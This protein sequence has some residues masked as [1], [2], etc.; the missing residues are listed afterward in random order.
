MGK[1]KLKLFV[2]NVLIY[3]LGGIMSKVVHLVMVPILTYL[4]PTTAFFGLSDNA[5][6]LLSFGIYLSIMGMFDA[7]YRLFFEKQD[8]MYKREVCSTTVF[9]T[10][11]TSVL[12]SILLILLK[13]VISPIVFEKPEYSYLIYVISLTTF[14]SATNGIISA[15]T[16]MQN[17]RH[18]FLITNTIGPII[19][20]AISVP[21]ILKGFYVIAMP[22]AALI[23]GLIIEISFLI[24]NHKWFSPKLFRKDLLKPL[25]SIAIPL[26]PNFLVYWVFNSC[27]KLMITKIL[28]LEQNGIYSVGAKLGMCSQ[29][30]YT[31][32]A[33]GWQYFAFSTMNEKNQIKNNSDI[34]EY[35]GA[36]SFV[37]T[38]FLCAVSSTI[39]KI[40]PSMYYSGYIVAPYLFLAPLLLML[41]QVG[42]NQFL[43]IK[44]TWPNVLILGFGA[45]VNLGLNYVLIP[46][47]GIEGASV[48]TLSGY[49]VSLIILCVVL[50]KMRLMI[51][52]RRFCV[53][54]IA[55]AFYMLIWRMLFSENL[56]MGLTLGLV[57]A[58][59]VI[60]LYKREIGLM[61]SIIKKRKVAP[62]Q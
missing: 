17:K 46:L 55:L 9:F 30:I 35:L 27:D 22:L 57:F 24:M 56:L 62:T 61:T 40:F 3:G 36:I 42:S 23:S 60:L 48:A 47:I 58:V 20:Y 41:Y 6:T 52:S 43:V 13:D 19:S 44:K 59:F 26:L 53:M 18:V 45:I 38:A 50:V 28:G 12:T 5:N 51:L 33:G 15:P 2:E 8:E 34:F 25:L 10:L 49:I 4:F 16:R 14:V 37:A 31:A 11:G 21:M 32:F 54:V 7:M 1:S 39:F 29:L